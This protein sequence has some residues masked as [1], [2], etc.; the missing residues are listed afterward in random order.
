MMKVLVL[1]AAGQLGHVMAM[2]LS[3]EYAV[4]AWTR[5]DIDLRRH[6]E[7]SERLRRLAPEVI[8]N[9]ASYNNVDQAEQD[10]ETAIDVNGFVVRTLAH[11]AEA[12]DAL[13]IQYSTDFVFLGT[14]TV[15]YT[16]L[17]RPEP[18]SVYA[19]SKLIGEWMAAGAP[20][21]YVLR[22]ESLF[23]GPMRRSSV[24]RIAN[25]VRSGTPAPV[26]VDRVVSPSF[27]I[28]VAEA[29]AHLIRTR[30]A[31]GV[32]H[33]VNS[34]HATWF[35]VGREIARLLGK[36]ESA[37]KPIRVKDVILPAARPQY[38]ALDNAKLTAT[39]CVL[40]T[41]QDAI[42]RYISTLPAA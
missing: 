24:D 6:R 31:Y 13:L 11:A 21:H 36:T 29:S 19:Q 41:W 35:E 8:I 39:G 32:Y 33:C 25:A 15:P 30:P 12:I 18:Q 22:V 9:C 3:A 20:K 38:A 14:G 28:D 26:F 1:G 42:A 23:G 10:Q 37:L 4:T 34:G 7:L 40:P 27:V 17:D 5:E 16:E 2:L